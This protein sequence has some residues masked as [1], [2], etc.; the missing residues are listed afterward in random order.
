MTIKVRV[1]HAETQGASIRVSLMRVP[2]NDSPSAQAAAVSAS[3]TELQPGQS[4]EFYVYSTQQLRVEEVEYRAPVPLKLGDICDLASTP[5]SGVLTG[6]TLDGMRL[7][8]DGQVY[9]SY[10]KNGPYGMERGGCMLSALSLST[11]ATAGPTGPIGP[12][13]SSDT[14]PEYARME[15]EWKAEYGKRMSQ[16]P[17]APFF[18]YDH[19]PPAL[20]AISKP[21]CDLAETIGTLVPMHQQRN[22]ALQKLIEAKDCAVRAYL[23]AEDTK[24]FM[25][26]KDEW[27]KLMRPASGATGPGATGS[28]GTTGPCAVMGATG[29]TGPLGPQAPQSPRQ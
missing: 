17:V 16:D 27:L 10:H 7:K 22:V 14:L 29:W 6:V 20:A 23:G 28:G 3:A 21:F 5:G 24:A 8:E 19:L 25:A 18:K 2:T 15:I 4:A 26:K 11:P 1:T 12:T 13:G 9:A